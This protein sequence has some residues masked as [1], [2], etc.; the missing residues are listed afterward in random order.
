MLSSLALN[1]WQE[2]G[3]S[4]RLPRRELSSKDAT[5]VGKKDGGKPTKKSGR[6]FCYIYLLH[7]KFNSILIIVLNSL[8][9]LIL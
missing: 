1:M 8:K 9:F 2:K 5:V 7:L 3:N 4:N 6:S